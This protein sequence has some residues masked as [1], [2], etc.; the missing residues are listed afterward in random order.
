LQFLELGCGGSPIQG[1]STVILVISSIP[2]SVRIFHP[3]L[4]LYN[5]ET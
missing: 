3:D 4:L 5:L 2:S 1:Y